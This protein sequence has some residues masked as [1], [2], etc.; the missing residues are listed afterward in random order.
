MIK[1]CKCILHLNLDLLLDV[2]Q[3]KTKQNIIRI[4]L[5]SYR[6]RA[7]VSHQKGSVHDPMM[8]VGVHAR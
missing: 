2:V 4:S 1:I 6:V 3:S 8:C 7:C 5:N